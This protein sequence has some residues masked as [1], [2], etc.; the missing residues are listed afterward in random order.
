M[1]KSK[2]GIRAA[3]TDG[4]DAIRCLD[5][6]NIYAVILSETTSNIFKEGMWFKAMAPYMLLL[7]QS[8]TAVGNMLTL[9]GL[10][11]ALVGVVSGR[12]MINK[13]G[14]ESTWVI[15]GCLGVT[16][17]AVNFVCMCRGS[18]AAAYALSFTWAV[19]NGLWNSC[20]ETSWARSIVRHKREDVNGA[21]QIANKATT[22]L[23]PLFSAALFLSFGNKW[24]VDLVQYVMLIGTAL[25]ILP[26]VLCFS[27]RRS[28]E[29]DQELSLLDVRQMVFPK[30]D[31]DSEG[32]R[33]ILGSDI[34][35]DIAHLKKSSF[36]P[37]GDGLVK[38]TYPLGVGTVAKWHSRIR[39]LSAD[40]SE[41][42]YLLGKQYHAGFKG[43]P[44]TDRICRIH[45]AD[46]SI[47]AKRVKLESL[48]VFL[49]AD[50]SVN[51]EVSKVRFS[52]FP[53]LNRLSR[54][55]SLH[56][57]ATKLGPW[58]RRSTSSEEL[59]EPLV[60]EDEEGTGE[61]K[62]S[63]T[64]K[65]YRPNIMGANVIVACDVLNAVGSGMSLK[66]LDL[67]LLR[68]YHVSPAGVFFVA[69]LVNILGAFFT[70]LAKSLIVRT[71]DMGYKAKLM[72][73]LL[74]SVSL[75]FL[76]L[77]C[78][79]GMPLY[80]VVLS[81]VMMQSLNSCTKAFNRAQLVNW[82]PR[83]KVATYMTWDSLNKAN[84]G[85]VTIF[86]AQL[87][88][89]GGSYG[90]RTC[91][92]A[93]FCILFVRICVYLA[94]TLRKGTVYRGSKAQEQAVFAAS[95]ESDQGGEAGSHFIS[96]ECESQMFSSQAQ[97]QETISKVSSSDYGRFVICENFDPPERPRLS[98][99]RSGGSCAES[100]LFDIAEHEPESP[101]RL[102][103]GLFPATPPRDPSA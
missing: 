35:I 40:L 3:C 46:E 27:F 84:Q 41:S 16:G 31:P 68:D 58:P 80:V 71:R 39:I 47:R 98:L 102:R 99:Q 73:V 7:T 67:F 85:G 22:A 57:V 89:V 65:E 19:Y 83:D 24:S 34:T 91:F 101:E 59:K 23:G 1:V 56:R 50:K 63:K 70:P 75:A 81:I 8:N 14:I 36:E 53:D 37:M 88:E 29:V 54:N 43:V 94:F 87:V 97:E 93:T 45:F 20:L 32:G 60:D 12:V 90:Y 6:S 96:C 2:K 77:L 21:R 44:N 82:L 10:T 62:K 49:H 52:L 92:L 86:G 66:F 5:N 72:V 28:Q 48:S 4:F 30:R 61:K 69:F 11:R 26:V 18:V 64:K 9:N 74:W 100:D 103:Q 78:V 25:T 76:G 17:L 13:M 15:T 51:L 95:E 55:W 79:P 33:G 42:G 38:L